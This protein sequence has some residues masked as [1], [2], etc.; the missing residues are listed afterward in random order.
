MKRLAAALS[1]LAFAPA[2]FA[3]QGD[4][5][6]VRQNIERLSRLGSVMMIAAHPDD[7]NT[8]VLAYYAQGK[9]FRTAYLSLTRGEGGQNLIGPEQ[10]VSMGLIRTQELLAARRMDG[11]RQYFTRAIDFGF[12]KTA[13]ET[14]ARWGRDEILGDVVFAIRRFRPDIVLLRFSGTPRDGH[15]HH[16]SSAILGREAFTAAADPASFP[17][18]L[19]GGVKPWQARR[20]YWNVFSFNRAMEQQA[21]AMKGVLSIDTGE[22]DPALGMSYGEIAG[23]SR[24][25]HRSQGMGAPQPKGAQPNYLSPIAGDP[26]AK[27]PF[28]GIDTSWN[29]IPGGAAVIPLLERALRDFRIEDPS[30][31]VPA[32]VD[33]RRVIAALDDPL[34]REKLADLDEVLAAAAGLWLD[35]SAETAVTTPGSSLAI[36]LTAVNRSRVPVTLHSV[37]ADHVAAS[38]AKPGPL[39][40]NK[41]L[42]WT[43]SA[44]IPAGQ[45]YTQPYW[46]REPPSET[47]Y[48]IA[49]RRLIGLPELGAALEARFKLDIAGAAVELSRPV[50][51]RYVDRVRGELTRPLEI[52]PPVAVAFTRSAIVFADGKPRKIEVELRSKKAAGEVALEAPAGW[53]IDPPMQPFNIAAPGGLAVVAFQVTPPAH[54]ARA[55]LKA[56]ARVNG[57]EI[58]HGMRTIEYEHIP[59]QTIYPL[60]SVP[61]V[62][63]DAKVLSRRIGYVMGAGDEVP[64]ALRQ[65]GLDVA[66]LTSEDLARADLSSFDAIVTGVRAYNVRDDLH[67]SQHRLIGYVNAGGTLIVQYNVQEGGPFGGGDPTRLANIGP[68]PLKVSRD[69]VTVE[70]AP[71]KPVSPDIPLLT[72]PNRIADTDYEGWVQER[73]LYFASE[74]DERYQP[75]WESNDPG[76]KPSRGA[77]LFARHGKGVYIFTPL[78]WFRQ[79]PAGVPGAYRIFANFLSA[80][81]VAAA[82]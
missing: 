23:I 54:A 64:Q 28:E 80:G 20:L 69:R 18:Q 40:F 27:D 7:E 5:L 37:T 66:L 29:R 1:A 31:A 55:E 15:G 33:A 76:E 22:F 6:D 71:L 58:R 26:A 8:A 4:S 51:N 53:N 73:G 67:S 39:E 68:Y 49:G 38:K 35:A 12:S 9:K 56:A 13:E 42:T 78:A 60:A 32:L 46:L 14:L 61:V 75:L 10:G 62:R 11:A 21:A 70:D 48:R 65:L 77:T 59:P 50:R 52:V 63:T 82:P 36:R 41:P 30:A 74:W 16:Q 79:L 17:E 81:K 45:P 34:A 19:A 47:I 25:Q 24:S 3:A 44:S 2:A 72:A 57:L 43:D